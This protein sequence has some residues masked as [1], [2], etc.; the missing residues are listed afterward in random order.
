[1][2]VPNT[3]PSSG[4][5]PNGIS[6]FPQTPSGSIVTSN[7]N[8]SLF[9]AFGFKRDGEI[10][11]ARQ[12]NFSVTLPNK[13]PVQGTLPF[14]LSVT[15]GSQ[16]STVGLPAGF[17]F[18]RDELLELVARQTNFSVTLPNKLPVQGTLPFGLS[19]TQ[20]A[21]NSTVGLSAGFPFKRE[22]E[23]LEARQISNFTFTLPNKL[24]VQGTLPFGLT[25]TQ[26]SQNSTVGLPA[27]F[28]F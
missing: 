10:L 17:P 8:S 16:N 21:Q 9:G 2:N 27:G 15:Q 1:M 23:M 13:L 5:F 26:G 22:E 24:P 18:K 28:P 11:E 19:V 6:V 20:G 12:T 14:G 4:S 3:V 7:R 25:V